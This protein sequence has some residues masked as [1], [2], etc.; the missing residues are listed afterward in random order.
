MARTAY[1]S[2]TQRPRLCI[3]LL[4][5]TLSSIATIG[6]AQPGPACLSDPLNPLRTIC[7][8]DLSASQTPQLR[9]ARPDRGS[10][11]ARPDNPGTG[12]IGQRMVEQGLEPVTDGIQR[13]RPGRAIMRGKK[14]ADALSPS[15]ADVACLGVPAPYRLACQGFVDASWPE[16]ISPAQGVYTPADLERE[17]RRIEG[18]L[19][20]CFPRDGMEVPGRR[21]A[22]CKSESELSP[23]EAQV[24]ERYKREAAAHRTEVDREFERQRTEVWPANRDYA[25]FLEIVIQQMEQMN[26]QDLD[27]AFRRELSTQLSIH[28]NQL[29]SLE[30]RG[31]YPS[32]NPSPYGSTPASVAPPIPQRPPVP[33]PARIPRA[34]Q[35]TPRSTTVA[36]NEPR[37]PAG[38]ACASR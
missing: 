21:R 13:T 22:G 17:G 4:T 37:C 25:A 2:R 33:A 10:R 14:V 11:P 38:Y 26:T 24:I 36:S 20:T 34:Q 7:P 23:E 28:R 6:W 19:R 35:P 8:A 5:I 16:S 12:A 1:A 31:I 32:Q 27:P 30:Q 18:G 15:P 3:G 9:A 29:R